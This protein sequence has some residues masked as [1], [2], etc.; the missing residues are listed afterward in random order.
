MERAWNKI[1]AFFE[2]VKFEH[3]VFALP[4]AYLGMLLASDGRPKISQFIWIT[5]AM[6]SARTAAMALNRLIDRK[7]DAA[8]PRTQSRPLLTG[9]IS[10][11][12]AWIAVA[13]SVGV[14]LL[15]AYQLNTLCFSLAPV[16]LFLLWG[17]HYVKRFSI[18]CHFALGLVLALAPMGGWMAVTGAFAWQPLLLSAAVLFWVAGFDIIYALQDIEFD[19]AHS[20]YSIPAEFGE[21]RA[22]VYSARCHIA[23]VALLGLFGLATGLGPVYWAG[24]AVCAGLLWFEHHIASE[25]DA[26]KLNTAFFTINGWVGILLFV[27][28]FLETFR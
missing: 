15:S 11:R 23:S 21:R 4:F 27:F 12:A 1:K 5:A 16:A 9:R 8:N 19:R 6:V 3:S 17:Y 18:L 25:S 10:A 26:S 28:T 24:V 7:I 13:V 20:L 22:L 14:L 2:L